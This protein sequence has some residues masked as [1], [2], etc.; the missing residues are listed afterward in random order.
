[1]RR[2]QQRA[3][4][5]ASGSL[6]QRYGMRRVNIRGRSSA[7]KTML[8]TTIA[9]NLKK[10]LKHQP[11]QVLRLAIALPKPAGKQRLLPFWRKYYRR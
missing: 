3:V 11:K 5:P 10:L 8:L 9:F 2:L 4:E 1:M 7:H 6:L